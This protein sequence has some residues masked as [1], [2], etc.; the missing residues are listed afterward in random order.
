MVCSLVSIYFDSSKLGIQ[1]KQ[2][3]YNFWLLIQ[4]YSQFWFFRKGSGN[5]F[6]TTFHK[7][8]FKKNIFRVIFYWPDFIFWLPLSWDIGQYFL[9]I[10]SWPVCHVINFEIKLIFLIKLFLTKKSRQNF[11]YIENKK[12]FSQ[13]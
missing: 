3:A 11:K 2:T 7:W 1:C 13:T 8:F 4:R 9:S 5:I 10:V 12:S 6:S